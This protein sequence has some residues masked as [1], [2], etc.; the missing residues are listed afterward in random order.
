MDSRNAGRMYG[1]FCAGRLGIDQRSL[2][3]WLGFQPDASV[4]LLS[5]ACRAAIPSHIFLQQELRGG[6]GV[7]ITGAAI[8]CLPDQKR[9]GKT[10]PT[11]LKFT[12]AAPN[13]LLSHEGNASFRVSPTVCVYCQTDFVT[14]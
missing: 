12:K 4:H 1:S 5:G 10:S 11:H 3:L 6:K 7:I 2:R 14:C 13:F 8:P 9:S